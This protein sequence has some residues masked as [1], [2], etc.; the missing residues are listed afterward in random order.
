MSNFKVVANN[1]LNFLIR[2]ND[3]LISF[4]LNY[5]KEK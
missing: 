1:K 3:Q 2:L 4:L 5:R